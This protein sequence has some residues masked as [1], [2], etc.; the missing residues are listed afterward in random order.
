M[1]VEFVTR[2]AS[3]LLGFEGIFATAATGENR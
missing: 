1:F 3:L 2:T